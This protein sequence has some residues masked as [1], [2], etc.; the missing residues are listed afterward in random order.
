MVLH[1]LRLRAGCAIGHSWHLDLKN[2]AT[3]FQLQTVN[4]RTFSAAPNLL[5]LL[6]WQQTYEI[7][8]SQ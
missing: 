1:S 3:N 8:K 7:K 4:C 2:L 5:R 6:N